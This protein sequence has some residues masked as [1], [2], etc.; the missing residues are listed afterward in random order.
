[1]AGG[2]IYMNVCIL[3]FL[4][5]AF[6]SC[7]NA[8]EI[9]DLGTDGGTCEMVIQPAPIVDAQIPQT[10]NEP[11]YAAH[12]EKWTEGSYTEP[13]PDILKPY[14]GKSIFVF[15]ANDAASE[16]AAIKVQADMGICVDYTGLKDVSSF[17]ERTKITFP[18][19]LANDYIVQVFGLKSYPVL[20]KVKEDSVEYSTD[21]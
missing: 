15:G 4:Y 16:A 10:V 19:Q 14:I 7:A 20:V 2:K 11:S 21:F 18:V 12:L 9:T 13:R 17:R 8:Q 1:L 5:F 6:Y 3:L